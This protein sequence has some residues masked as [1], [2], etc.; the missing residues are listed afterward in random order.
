LAG[1]RFGPGIGEEAHQ[2]GSSLLEHRAEIQES[3]LIQVGQQGP[4]ALAEP[5]VHALPFLL[6]GAA[7]GQANADKT[8]GKGFLFKPGLEYQWIWVFNWHENVP[9]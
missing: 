4:S 9:P 1:N 8:Q 6:E 3:G 2:G 5:C 7:G